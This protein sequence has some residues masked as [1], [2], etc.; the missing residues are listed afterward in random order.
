MREQLPPNFGSGKVS[1]AQPASPKLHV[2]VGSQAFRWR[3]ARQLCRAGG[4]TTKA[5]LFLLPACAASPQP[6]CD[7]Y[8]V[9]SPF[10]KNPPAPISGCC[11]SAAGFASFPFPQTPSQEQSRGARS[12]QG[13]IWPLS[14]QPGVCI[15][16]S[17]INP[18]RLVPISA[19]LPERQA[20]L[21]P[22]YA[23]S[24]PSAVGWEAVKSTVRSLSPLFQ[25][26]LHRKAKMDKLQV[27]S[28]QSL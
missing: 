27:S 15:N 4:P 24:F 8:Q 28:P 18:S 14:A 1:A 22:Q 20:H 21:P 12:D 6:W 11:V 26:C 7:T 13:R 10:H 17:W 2:S 19:C 5:P 25:P 3:G 23:P 16:P 9:E